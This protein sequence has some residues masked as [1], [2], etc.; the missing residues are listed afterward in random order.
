VLTYGWGGVGGWGWGVVIE[1]GEGGTKG[2]GDGVSS[3]SLVTVQLR[4]GMMVCT[5]AGDSTHALKHS[6]THL[7]HIS[8]TPSATHH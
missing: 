1:W 3:L 6:P 7:N 8:L 4:Q 2:E 5:A